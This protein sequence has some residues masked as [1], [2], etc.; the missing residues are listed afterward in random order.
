VALLSRFRRNLALKGLSDVLT[1]GLTF[2]FTI[3]VARRL[4]SE[5]LGVYT[6]AQNVA[7]QVTI[8]ADLGIHLLVT[9]EVAARRG[10]GEGA[11]PDYVGNLLSLKLTLTTLVLAVIGALTLTPAFGDIA[12]P[13]V[14]S[15][16]FMVAWS[17][18][19]FSSSVLCGFERMEWEAV[20]KGAGRML[21]IL[22]GAGAL[23]TGRGLIGV[24]IGM[25][26][27]PMI[28][29][30]AL[31]VVL[32]RRDPSWRVRWHRGTI[33][34]ALGHA[35][36]LAVVNL[37]ATVYVRIDVTLLKAL[38]GDL[39]EIGIYSGAVIL[40]NAFGAVALVF[41]GAL[42]PMFSDLV[43]TRPEAF[44]SLA[45]DVLRIMAFAGLPLFATVLLLA[46]WIV[47][48]LG[49]G[50]AESATAL[51]LLIGDVP[52]LYM[53]VQLTNMMIAAGRQRA[54]L[55]PGAVALLVNVGLNLALIP[56]LGYR[57]AAIATVTTEAV[58]FVSVTVVARD[59]LPGRFP[60]FLWRYL[61]AGLAAGA[62]LYPLR[63]SAPLLALAAAAPVY[64]GTLWLLGEASAEDLGRLRRL[65]GARLTGFL[66]GGARAR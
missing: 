57:G 32:R 3:V 35:L 16:F 51:R 61:V 66:T 59:L 33:R 6:T 38:R 39:H 27:A 26:A 44:R 52:I 55:V 1:R 9:R 62:A 2:I 10:R 54:L 23:F 25:A 64:L 22:L 48:I 43:A 65:A 53:N 8:L 45:R 49:R 42:F 21:V 7:Y 5:S 63:D 4:G 14:I 30:V 34:T 11:I 37:M 28:V 40:L 50:Y 18:L 15:G 58:L 17:A 36:P 12:L 47:S 19:E 29:L 31:I 46:P 60:L 13:L 41:S 56:F 24:L 20:L